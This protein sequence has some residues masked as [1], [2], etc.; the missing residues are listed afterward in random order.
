MPSAV[1]A[2]NQE[3]RV[4]TETPRVTAVSARVDA[5]IAPADAFR[6]D[7]P[8]QAMLVALHP[9]PP[10]QAMLGALHPHPPPQRPAD[11]FRRASPR[12]AVFRPKPIANTLPLVRADVRLK[13][14]GAQQKWGCSVRHTELEV[15]A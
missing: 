1:R 7:Q 9:D 10:L 5:V 3:A 12:T 14:A 15:P 13:Q 8:L 6:R 4:S 2:I 11:A